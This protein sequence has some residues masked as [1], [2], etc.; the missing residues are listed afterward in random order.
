MELTANDFP[1]LYDAA[2]NASIKSQRNHIVIIRCYL[3][4]LIVG[5][6]TSVYQKEIPKAPAIGLIIFLATLF[7][8]ILQSFKRFDKIWYNGRAVA[9]SIKTR[10]WRYMMQAEPYNAGITVD[11]ASA[12][13]RNDLKEI[14]KE[15]KD[16][17]AYL[18]PTQESGVAVTEKMKTIRSLLLDGRISIYKTDRIDDQRKWYARMAGFNKRQG[19]FWFIALITTHILIILLFILK[20]YSPDTE[21][22]ADVLIIAA[23]CIVTWTQ[24]KRYHDLSTAYTLTAREIGIIKGDIES[25]NT[26]ASFS[27]FVK[28]S[29]NAFSREHTQWTARKDT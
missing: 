24:V 19:Q 8:T 17:G 12:L 27:N 10:T 1:E 5:S 9:E 18:S 25:I 4:L 14:L 20:I 13:F 11:E 21:I 29:E 3:L 2:N 23:G 22:P 26:E 6:A 28:D 7:L 16:L 15:N